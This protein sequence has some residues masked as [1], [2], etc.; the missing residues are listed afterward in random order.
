MSGGL[1]LFS[2]QVPHI[3]IQIQL[4]YIRQILKLISISMYGIYEPKHFIIIS[5]TEIE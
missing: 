5:I 3:E 4:V 2:L 1:A